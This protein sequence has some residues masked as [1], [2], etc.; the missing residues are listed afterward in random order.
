MRDDDRPPHDEAIATPP[1]AEEHA[2]ERHRDALR[3]RFPLP[4]AAQLAR[5][6]LPKKTLVAAAVLALATAVVWLD[7][8]YRTESYATAIGERLEI[9]LADGSRVLLNTGSRLDVAWRLRSRRA[10]LATGQVLFDV[11]HERVRP[12]TV[13]AGAVRVHVVGTAFDVR[14][15]AADVAITVLRGRVDVNAALSERSSVSLTP[16][17]RVRAHGDVLG[18]AEPVD[19]A[20]QTAWKDG[21]LLFDRTALV[22]VLVEI[23]RYSRTPI[24]LGDQR[25]AAL[26]V[27]G[28]FS[29][30]NSDDLL[31]LLPGIL[32]VRL[33]RGSDGS[34]LVEA[35]RK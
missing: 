13:D 2:L 18:V 19:A 29:I 1:C 15:D 11:A 17:Q 30:D 22:D 6:R 32:P 3:E 27:S 23:Q 26:K 31:R 14:R 9:A 25:L 5:R 8:V 24:A 16:G 21:K 34:V 20:A 28:V 10:V 4:D 33:A 35:A 12:F 7:P